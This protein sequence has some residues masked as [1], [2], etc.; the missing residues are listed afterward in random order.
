MS[1]CLRDSGCLVFDGGRF[2][3]STAEELYRVACKITPKLL[4][5]YA[6]MRSA[7]ARARKTPS[8]LGKRPGTRPR[9]AG[10]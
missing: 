9:R 1:G 4:S 3:G 10:A 6:P 7:L 2:L 8:R 5:R